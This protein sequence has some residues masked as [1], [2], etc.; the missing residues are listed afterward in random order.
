MKAENVALGVV[1]EGHDA[2]G[3]VHYFSDGVTVFFAQTIGGGAYVRYRKKDGRRACVSAETMSGTEAPAGAA[4]E[5][6]TSLT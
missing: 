3:R 4:I 1:D 6:C 2:Y 5:R